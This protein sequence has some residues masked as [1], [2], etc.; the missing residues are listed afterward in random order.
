M[1]L[2]QYG[3]I[4]LKITWVDCRESLWCP[5]VMS[6][7]GNHYFICI[8]WIPTVEWSCYRMSVSCSC[9]KASVNMCFRADICAFSHFTLKHWLLTRGK[10]AARSEYLL[11]RNGV[12]AW[13]EEAGGTFSVL[14][15]AGTEKGNDLHAPETGAVVAG[16]AAKYFMLWWTICRKKP[17]EEKMNKNL[18]LK[19]RRRTK[20]IVLPSRG[21]EFFC[22][23]PRTTV[24]VN[25]RNWDCL[26]QQPEGQKCSLRTESLISVQ[27]HKVWN[28]LELRA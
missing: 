18:H 14:N 2:G 16:G 20:T 26:R 10:R 4:R 3:W 12:G 8:I 27:D 6:W 7:T 13:S 25:T 9:V 17:L 24:E 28:D 15:T 5:G 22:D 1:E 19:S 21:L 11:N 23:K